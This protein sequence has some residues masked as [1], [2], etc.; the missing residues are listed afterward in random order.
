MRSDGRISSR[1]FF[2]RFGGCLPQFIVND[3]AVLSVNHEYGLLDLDAFDFIGKDRK[4][5]QT[6]LFEIAE[7]LRVDNAWIAIGGEI[8]T[9]VPSMTQGFF[10]LGEQDQSANGWFRRGH[11]QA[12]GSGV[13]SDQRSLRRQNRRAHWFPAT[14]GEEQRPDHRMFPVRTESSLVL[15]FTDDTV[16]MASA[17]RTVRYG[18]PSHNSICVSL[19]SVGG[20]FELSLSCV[21]GILR[22][23]ALA[24]SPRQSIPV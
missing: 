12:R 19:N 10:E 14:P 1:K 21:H 4:R 2:G 20:R 6:K 15:A 18:S 9:P 11:Q 7:S 22:F 23:V 24:W 13:Y 3:S 16:G 17:V 8:E 5:V